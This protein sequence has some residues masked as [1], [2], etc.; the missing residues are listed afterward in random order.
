MRMCQRWLAEMDG[1]TRRALTFIYTRRLAL[2]ITASFVLQYWDY[3]TYYTS[4]V[5]SS[6]VQLC[7]K[8]APLSLREKE[9]QSSRKE[10]G[11]ENGQV[12]R[13]GDTFPFKRDQH[14][15]IFT[16]RSLEYFMCPLQTIFLQRRVLFVVVVVRFYPN[17]TNEPNRT[18]EEHVLYLKFR[19]TRFSIIRSPSPALPLP[20]W[21]VILSLVKEQIEEVH[22]SA[23]LP[24]TLFRTFQRRAPFT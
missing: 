20:C 23:C 4:V 21:F 16:I 9:I 15:R 7:W 1:C 5:Y 10:R 12:I 24:F 2:A 22:W 3:C 19:D 11:Q 14:S 18:L 13:I 6:F 17:L 8:N